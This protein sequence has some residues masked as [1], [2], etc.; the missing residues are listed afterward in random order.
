MIEIRIDITIL[1]IKESCSISRDFIPLMGT[2]RKREQQ[3][4]LKQNMTEEKA[5]KT[6][7]FRAGPIATNPFSDILGKKF[8]GIISYK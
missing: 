6:D 4:M 8:L 7:Q 5:T 3:P 1:H 2:R